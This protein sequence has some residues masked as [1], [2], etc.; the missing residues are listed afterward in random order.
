MVFGSLSIAQ[1]ITFSRLSAASIGGAGIGG[2]GG[3]GAGGAGGEIAISDGTINA[4]SN[5]GAGIGGGFSALQSGGSGGDITITGGTV[6]AAGTGG[7]GIGGGGSNGG[8]GGSDGGRITITGGTVIATSSENGTGIGAGAFGSSGDIAISSGVPAGTKIGTPSNIYP[9]RTITYHAGSKTMGLVYTV[10]PLAA[11]A[12][13]LQGYDPEFPVLEPFVWRSQDESHTYQPGGEITSTVTDLYVG[14]AAAKNYTM[15]RDNYRFENGYASFGYTQDYRIPVARYAKLF[16]QANAQYLYDNVGTWG[17]SCFGFSTTDLAFFGDTMNLSAYS[18]AGSIYTIPAPASPSAELTQL[19]ETFQISQYAAYISDIMHGTS[20]NQTHRLVQAVQDF[21]N[22]NRDLGVVIGVLRPS[23]GGHAVVPY[24]VQ[25]L[26]NNNY[27]FSIYD[28]N[29]PDD[30]GRKMIVNTSTNA[31]SY[32]LWDGLTF[33]SASGYGDYFGFMPYKEVYNLLNTAID[34]KGSAGMSVSAPRGAQI[35]DA[36]GTDI[37]N[38]PGAYENIPMRLMP[39]AQAPENRMFTIPAGE[40]TVSPGSGKSEMSLLADGAYFNVSTGNGATTL[41]VKAGGS[42]FVR[43]DS[44]TAN[45]FQIGYGTNATASRPLVLSGTASGAFT[46]AADNNGLLV[47]GTATLTAS[48]GSHSKNYTIPAGQS[49]HISYDMGDGT[50]VSGSSD[51]GRG[52]SITSSV[53]ATTWWIEAPEA[54][55]LANA[56]KD[57]ALGYA[58]SSRVGSTG[59]RVSALTE[60]AGLRF[61]HDTTVDSAKQVRVSI[62]NPAK[63]TN[64]TLLSGSVKGNAVDGI[65]ASFEKWFTNKVRVVSF[66]Q[67]GAWGQP[68][69]IAAKVDLTGMEITKLH[70]YSYDKKVNIYRS[71]LKPEYLIDVNGYLHFT[72]EYAGDIIISEGA[73]ATLAANPDSPADVSLQTAGWLN[74]FADVS[75]GDWFYHNVAHAHTNGL[76]SGTSADSFSP[77]APMTRGML[78]TVLGRMA[79]ADV[80]SYK[81]PG[82]SDVS[83]DKYYA[84]YVAW[85]QENGIASGVGENRFAPENT[86][87]RQDLAVLL[88]RYAEFAGLASFALNQ[89]VTFADAD[90]VATYAKEAAAAMQ[91]AG[92]ISGKPGNL[93]DPLGNATRAETAAM[94][95]RFSVLFSQPG[96]AV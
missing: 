88:K 76:F 74:P 26:G 12:L 50:P 90:R 89:A 73:L 38:V 52:D 58:S 25:S 49:V 8:S 43:I 2:G 37:N 35:K 84:P 18:N 71:V 86:I 40:Y 51:S 59:I 55:S 96:N 27:E 13:W 85:A 91:R 66:E 21:Q 22:G 3:I 82:F 29:W 70:F 33:D 36:S 44:S 75:A 57:S 53:P 16:G 78:V 9:Q 63:I 5:L 4:T 15:G 6:I 31:W 93:F 67:Q 10:T 45:S 14:A 80:S 7:A 34:F 65:K 69:R 48:N 54:K 83:A 62:S 32:A 56:A 94:L 92:V 20:K 79:N 19:F 64:D 17:G 61:E 42:N 72:T 87:S 41:T 47:T 23:M 11:R 60:L 24:A 28:N 30:A 95:H 46:A 81:A 1:V 39:G 77:Q 68:A